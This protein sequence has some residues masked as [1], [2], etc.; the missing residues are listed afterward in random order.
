MR[1]KR[2]GDGVANLTITAEA[3]PKK[4]ISK[5]ITKR[6]IDGDI[7]RK[8]FNEVSLS[9]R[10]KRAPSNKVFTTEGKSLTKA[11]ILPTTVDIITTKSSQINNA[12]LPTSNLSS[13]TAAPPL[14][15]DTDAAKTQRAEIP[16]QNLISMKKNENG[17]YQMHV[18]F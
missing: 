8:F 10:R 14:S 6:D 11:T 13:P 17:A 9:R 7:V 1:L 5:D 16:A 18:R 15:D 2:F 12:S 4:A 3:L